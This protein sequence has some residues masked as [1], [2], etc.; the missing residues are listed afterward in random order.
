M[1]TPLHLGRSALAGLL[2]ACAPS[3]AQE[4][5]SPTPAPFHEREF[6]T[7]ILP[8]LAKRCVSCHGIRKS[9]GDLRLDGHAGAAAGGNSSF[10]IL[11]PPLEDNELYARITSDD[12]DYR[13][14]R[15][16]PP[17]TAAEI[18]D[19]RRWILAGSPWPREP[20]KEVEVDP[21]PP[22][23]KVAKALFQVPLY[24]S[25]VWVLLIWARTR[26]RRAPEE[27]WG[28][29]ARLS[30][31]GAV[32]ILLVPLLA[33]MTY[34]AVRGY[35]G[36][37]PE[38]L[39]AHF[40]TELK[41]RLG[42]LRQDELFGDPPRPF[43]PP[44]APRMGGIYYRGNCERSPRLYR[45]GNYRTAAME[46]RLQDAAG[47]NLEVGDA[48]PDEVYLNLEIRRGKHTAQALFGPR[49]RAQV[50]LRTLP[51][52]PQGQVMAEA[53]EPGE[54][55]RLRWR[56]PAGKAEGLIYLCLLSNPQHG[57]VWDLKLQEGKIAAGSEVWMNA[58]DVPAVVQL[59]PPGPGKLPFT[60]WFSDEEIP[61]IEG[62]Q[63]TKDPKLLGVGDYIPQED[64]KS[65]D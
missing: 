50:S 31:P 42:D 26:A 17:L 23:V 4:A 28:P 43:H 10:P 2:I 19:F 47:K 33:Y 29:L 60:A 14:P 12:P 62:G 64:E 57:L 48:L 54:T 5:P 32:L 59:P 44:H 40:R 58:I 63:T 38:A 65:G 11:G 15:E 8:V 51:D 6:H 49:I 16:G 18:E 61:E 20:T 1:R 45:G 35:Q 9:E 56:L 24:L 46:L 34:H 52:E 27:E 30:L 7:K 13:M 37:N 25:L 21:V 53:T 36:S 55:W 39:E 41:T 22:W 3:F